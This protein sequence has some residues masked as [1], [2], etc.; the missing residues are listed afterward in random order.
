MVRHNNQI[1]NG[2][3]KKRWQRRVKTWFDQPLKKQRRRRLR[4]LNAVSDAPRP[5]AGLLRPIVQCPTIKYNMKQRSGRGF[6]LEELK[7]AGVDR[8]F[9]RNIGIS[10]DYRR[11]NR[12]EEHLRR[13]VERLKEY[14]SKLVLFPTDPKKPK[15]QDAKPEEIKNA[16]QNNTPFLFPFPRIADTQVLR[17][18]ESRAVTTEETNPKKSVVAR[19]KRARIA[20]RMESRRKIRKARKQNRLEMQ[21]KLESGGGKKGGD[22]KGDNKK[23]PQNK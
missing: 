10:V 8:N 21:K 20:E 23:A 1:P 7:V 2:H 17:E 11:R 4:H 18:S 13:N 15:K 12:N 16:T 22:K 6:T 5:V 19:S 14:R 9:A 3:F